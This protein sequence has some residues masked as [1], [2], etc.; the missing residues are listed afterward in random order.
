MYCATTQN[1]KALE[2]LID[3]RALSH[4]SVVLSFRSK[5]S[6]EELLNHPRKIELGSVETVE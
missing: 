1:L 5:E 4:A 3:T 2:N 6:F